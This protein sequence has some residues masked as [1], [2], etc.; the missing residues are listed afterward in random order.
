MKA[1]RTCLAANRRGA[2]AVELAIALPVLVI[3]GLGVA[4]AALGYE[5]VFV[6]NQA[7]H[8]GVEEFTAAGDNYS[9]MS[10]SAV[11]SEIATSAGVPATQVI[12]TQWLECNYVV[13]SP[14]VASCPAATI[15]ARYVKVVV[16]DTYSP[17]F[18]F[19]VSGSTKAQ[20]SISGS[21]MVRVA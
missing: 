4:D 10:V 2:A 21:A 20:I 13:Q 1:L 19:S 15:T 12:I 9:T 7:A 8:Q 6:L 11:Q 18:S 16:N 5:R 17:P 14:T 3:L